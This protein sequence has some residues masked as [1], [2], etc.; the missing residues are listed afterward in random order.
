MYDLAAYGAMIADAIRT[1]AYLAALRQSI[2]PNSV[3]LDIGAGTG[4]FALLACQLGARHVYAVEPSDQIGVARELAKDN[5]YGD[6]ITFIQSLSSKIS[7]PEPVD[8]VVSDLRGTLPLFQR[9]IP[10][11]IDV[12]QRF[13]AANGV[14]IPQKDTLWA[15]VV[16]APKLYQKVEQPWHNSPYGLNMA[17][18]R[19]RAINTTQKGLVT[20]EQFV[21][22]PQVWATL[23]YRTIKTQ[24]LSR[25]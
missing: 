14:L 18:A 16:E 7:L 3:V 11:M 19:Q 4:I 2:D 21:V 1:D 8:V 24:R 20:P 5:G 23:D 9:H 12:R 15:A 25:I 6:R 13:L 10:V 22:E 17:A